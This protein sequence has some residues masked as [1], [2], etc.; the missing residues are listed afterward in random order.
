MERTFCSCRSTWKEQ[1]HGSIG[2]FTPSQ[3]ISGARKKTIVWNRQKGGKRV[4]VKNSSVERTRGTQKR[5]SAGR[6]SVCLASRTGASTGGI[7]PGLWS[8]PIHTVRKFHYTSA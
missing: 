3:N 2:F 6:S 1:N 5:R 4:E 8:S 7:R